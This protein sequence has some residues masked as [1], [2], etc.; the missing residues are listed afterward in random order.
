MKKIYPSEMS[1][2]S[3]TSLINILDGEVRWGIRSYIFMESKTISLM[4]IRQQL[5]FQ[6]DETNSPAIYE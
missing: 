5:K 3:L 6:V 1:P 4:R 2:K